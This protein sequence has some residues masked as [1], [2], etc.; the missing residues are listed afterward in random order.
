MTGPAVI[1]SCEASRTFDRP[2]LVV[3]AAE[4]GVMP[5][6]HGRRPA[7]PLTGADRAPQARA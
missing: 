3:W 5:P 1:T 7:A 2:A 4:D 6:E